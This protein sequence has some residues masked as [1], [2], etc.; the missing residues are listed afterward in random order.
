MRLQTQTVFTPNRIVG[1]SV[2]LFISSFQKL[3]MRYLK[4]YGWFINDQQKIAKIELLIEARACYAVKLV[5][6]DSF[7][8][9]AYMRLQIHHSNCNLCA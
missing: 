6:S 2:T 5:Q 8:E 4:L 3:V 7:I 9:T 1:L